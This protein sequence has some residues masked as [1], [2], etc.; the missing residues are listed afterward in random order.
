MKYEGLI[1]PVDAAFQDMHIYQP[2]SKFLSRKNLGE[3]TLLDENNLL[4]EIKIKVK[5]ESKAQSVEE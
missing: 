2:D 4:S 5:D 3:G 1:S